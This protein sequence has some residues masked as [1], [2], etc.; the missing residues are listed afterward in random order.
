M[1]PN[2]LATWHELVRT[3]NPA[4]LDTLLDDDVVFYTPVVN[5]PQR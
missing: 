1:P 4:G 3:R 5:T 2:A